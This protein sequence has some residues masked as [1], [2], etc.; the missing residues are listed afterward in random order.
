MGTHVTTAGR[1]T[2]VRSHGAIAFADLADGTG[3]L[4]L[5]FARDR[6]ALRRGSL[7]EVEGS[8]ERSGDR[9]SLRVSRTNS[10]WPSTSTPERDAARALDTVRAEANLVRSR[11]IACI[12]RFFDARGWLPVTS[13][14]IVGDWVVGPT[15]SF[16]VDFYGERAYLAISNMIAHQQLLSLPYPRVYELGKLFRAERPSTRSRLAEFTI[17]DVGLAWSDLEDLL[18]VV[19]DLLGAIFS[20][21]GDLG[22]NRLHND[23]DT[24]FEH[25]AVAEVLEVV[26]PDGMGGSQLP[27]AAR[28]WLASQ[29]NGFVWVTG[30]PEH[31]RPA[32]VKA[33]D[34]RARDAQL[35]YRGRRYLAAGGERERDP[36]VVAAK[37]RARKM[38][39]ASYKSYLDALADG[40][41]PMTGMGLGLERLLATCLSGATVAD[42]T[43]FPR[44]EGHLEP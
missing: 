1:V 25:V 13:P 41:P 37:L 18:T 7:I 8:V 11:A 36:D 28:K 16:S 27:L 24:R 34:G 42:F 10:Y 30:F 31:T 12:H 23:V 43:W 26:G 20:E 5:I 38:S 40:A 9:L 21:V 19:E 39:V 35:W 4:Q 22:L 33:V 17:L 32:Y 44:Y 3:T 29:F 2:K 6:P 15:P 14:S